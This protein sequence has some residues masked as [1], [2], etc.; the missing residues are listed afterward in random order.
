MLPHLMNNHNPQLP[1]Q[2]IYLPFTQ[3]LPVWHVLG[4][5]HMY[6]S[7]D[8]LS[9][10]LNSAMDCSSNFSTAVFKPTIS[11]C[12]WISLLTE[13]DIIVNWKQRVPQCSDTFAHAFRLLPRLK[14]T[15]NTFLTTP[16]SETS[17]ASGTTL[18]A[19]MLLFSVERS[20]KTT[21]IKH[22]SRNSVIGYLWR[23]LTGIS[24]NSSSW[25]LSPSLSLVSNIS[26]SKWESW[27]VCRHE[28]AASPLTYLPSFIKQTLARQIAFSSLVVIRFG[29]MFAMC[30]DF[31]ALARW[32]ST[33]W[34]CIDK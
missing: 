20:S 10:I 25:P 30:I 33:C 8:I 3:H 17:W 27:I 26:T 18:A 5:C 9:W 29:K 1:S 6:L 14:R 16:A 21:W 7:P 28:T 31:P 2:R 13:W 11:G 12:L 19:V 23:C 24:D 15:W 32:L 22:N 34:K 4:S